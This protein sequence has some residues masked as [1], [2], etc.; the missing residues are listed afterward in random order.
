MLQREPCL[1]MRASM[2]V[3]NQFTLRE[4]QGHRELMSL[5]SVSEFLKPPST[6]PEVTPRYERYLTIF[7]N[8][9]FL[10]RNVLLKK[11]AWVLI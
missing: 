4:S 8:D 9:G 5:I 7:V 3:F 11:S 1:D 10:V 2:W 6:N